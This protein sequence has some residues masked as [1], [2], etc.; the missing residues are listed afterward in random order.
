MG[1][2]PGFLCRLFNELLIATNCGAKKSGVIFFRKF[3][4]MGGVYAAAY[5]LF[6][7]VQEMGCVRISSPF[8]DHARQDAGHGYKYVLGI[9]AMFSLLR[10]RVFLSHTFTD[11]FLIVNYGGTKR[12]ALMR[13]IA[14]KYTHKYHNI[15]RRIYYNEERKPNNKGVLKLPNR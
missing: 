2:V 14:L 3:E 1:G 12:A 6:R 7:I 9:V 4:N 10:N 11:N 8:P 5:M 15:T 13:V